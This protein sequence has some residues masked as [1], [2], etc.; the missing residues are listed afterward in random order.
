M[1]T[2]KVL[3]LIQEEFEKLLTSKT[4]WGRNELL[5]AFEKAKVAALA[6]MIDHAS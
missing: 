4:S 3:T 6:R 5:L 2:T 1:T